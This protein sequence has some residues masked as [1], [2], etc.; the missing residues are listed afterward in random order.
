MYMPA[1]GRVRA[2]KVTEG[3]PDVEEMMDQDEVF[4]PANWGSERSERWW[5]DVKDDNDDDADGVWYTCG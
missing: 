4:L 3:G 1:G 5:S 2:P